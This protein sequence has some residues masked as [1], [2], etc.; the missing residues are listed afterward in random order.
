MVLV[1]HDGLQ[2]KGW[3]TLPEG[4]PKGAVV[5]VHG[6]GGS[7]E[8]MYVVIQELQ[9][10]GWASLCYDGRAHG[11]SEGW[12]C[13]FG[14]QEK[15][16]V[17]TA[18]DWI[19]QQMPGLPVGIWG[20]SLGGSIATQALGSDPRLRFGV[21]ESSF[22][23]FR[24]IVRAYHLRKIP[25]LPDVLIRQNINRAGAIAG[26]P[27]DQVNPAD[28]AR[29]VSVPVLVAHGAADANIPISFGRELYDAFSSPQKVW[30][31]VPGAGHDDLE[32]TGGD[33]Y[34]RQVL[35]FLEHI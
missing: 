13:T 27:P 15:K 25:W 22:S 12:Y 14:W 19:A 34:F 20:H 35:S 1:T 30:L 8:G 11:E 32:E 6:I 5:V 21:I 29:K 16:D 18:L 33:D 10:A 31:S 4:Q 7:K 26:F 17:S 2:L 3:W 24:P 23:W 28:Y 9:R